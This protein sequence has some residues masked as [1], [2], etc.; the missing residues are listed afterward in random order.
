MLPPIGLWD[1]RRGSVEVEMTKKPWGGRFS[2]GTD[3]LVEKFTESIGFDARLYREDIEGSIAH[4]KMLA[5]QG[6]VSDADCERIVKALGEIRDEIERGQFPWRVEL[7]DVHLN[8]ERRLIEKI[9][10]AGGRL[11]TARSRNDQVVLD[12]KLYIKRVG[13][14]MVELMKELAQALLDQ[15]ERHMGAVMPFYTHLQRAQPVLLSHYLLAI[16]EMISR[17]RGRLLDCLRRLDSLP[18]GAGAGAGTSFPIDRRFVAREL[19]FSSVARN[20]LDAVSDR[21]FV[22]EFLAAAA[23]LFVH[24]SRFCED[25]VLW[26]SKEFDFVDLGDRFTTGSSMMP[27]KKNPDVAELVRGKSG[28]V[29]GAFVALAVTMKGLPF[30]YNRDMQ[31]DKEPLFDVADTVVSALEVLAGMVRNAT[32]KTDNMAR[33]LRGGFVTATDMADYLVR[34]GIPFRKAHEIVGRA[35]ALAEE[36]GRELDELTLDELK[37]ISPEF[38]RDVYSVLTVEGSV[39][40]RDSEG[41]TAPRRVRAMLA[42]CRRELAKW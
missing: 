23:I 6:I 17:D 21:D 29:T 13:G 30:A 22:M 24:L 9:G 15:A 27:Q 41:G 16:Y 31:E 19:G 35:V 33:A 40:S 14:R 3:R 8:I 11:H 2:E 25:L 1:R 36:T 39:R 12:E 37:A 42:R 38:E 32:F 4:V 28:R 34:K 7:E 10:D 20:S 5:R 18:L 26:S